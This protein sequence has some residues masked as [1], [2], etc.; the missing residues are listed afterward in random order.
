[1]RYLCLEAK[2]YTKHL[3]KSSYEH[4]FLFLTLCLIKSHWSIHCACLL[5]IWGHKKMRHSLTR[6]L[7][8][9]S[10]SSNSNKT[11]NLIISWSSWHNND[12]LSATHPFKLATE[13]CSDSASGKMKGP[14]Y[15]EDDVAKD[16]L[17]APGVLS[18]AN[19]RA[20][21]VVMVKIIFLL[22]FLIKYLL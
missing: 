17:T 7:A 13:L 14:E 21:E 16:D 19:W 4:F 12:K 10:S 5:R 1:M 6:F 11:V 2:K 8:S 15:T 18:K 3:V 22:L 9:F 20:R